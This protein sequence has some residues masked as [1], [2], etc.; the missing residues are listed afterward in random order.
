[1]QPPISPKLLTWEKSQY[2]VSQ[3]AVITVKAFQ[4]KLT[5][6]F[7]N[8]KRSASKSAWLNLVQKS[9]DYNV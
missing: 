7:K 9:L 4:V 8:S 5:R 3:H 1:M 2:A 6:H